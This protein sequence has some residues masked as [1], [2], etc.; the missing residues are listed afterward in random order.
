MTNDAQVWSP[1]SS[2]RNFAMAGM[3][4]NFDALIKG[5]IPPAKAGTP[6]LRHHFLNG[7]WSL[8]IGHWSFAPHVYYV[9]I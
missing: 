9:S 2:R 5:H 8:V 3:Q 1:G 4:D 7:H 6:N